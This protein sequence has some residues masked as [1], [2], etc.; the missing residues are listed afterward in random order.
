MNVGR[1]VRTAIFAAA[2]FALILLSGC[3][4][5]PESESNGVETK[6]PS[7]Y[8]GPK[9]AGR[10]Y[11][12]VALANIRLGFVPREP[13]SEGRPLK[14][15]TVRAVDREKKGIPANMNPVDLD[16]GDFE[17]YVDWKIGSGG[18]SGIYLRGRYEIQVGTEGGSNP[19]QEMGAVYSHHAADGRQRIGGVRDAFAD[20]CLVD[21]AGATGGHIPGL[22]HGTL[23]GG[24]K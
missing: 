22:L 24:G 12:T 14:K 8:E 4:P 21:V 9:S 16:Y 15:A 10:E 6:A 5:K 23:Q 19:K 18:D 17:M 20:Q 3:A 1:F 2:I 13:D 7:K 11:P